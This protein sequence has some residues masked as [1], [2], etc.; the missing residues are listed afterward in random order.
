MYRLKL[1]LL[2]C[3]IVLLSLLSGCAQ[4]TKIAML[5]PAEIDIKAKNIAVL[6]FKGD[7][8]TG[9]AGKL[10]AALTRVRFNGKP[11]FN[12][13][14]RQGIKSIIK[15]QKRQHNGL[16]RENVEVEV[17]SLVGA[18]ALISGRILALT[19]IDQN[20]SEKHR[21]RKCNKSS[22]DYID[23]TVR[24]KKRKISLSANIRITNITLGTVPY[25][26]SLSRSLTTTHC[27]DDEV[28]LP[29]KNQAA[30]FLAKEIAQNFIFKLKPNYEYIQVTLL[31]SED[32]DYTDHEESLLEDGLAYFKQKRLNKAEQLLSELLKSTQFKSYVAAYNLGVIKETKG[33]LKEAEKY[34]NLADSLQIEPVEEINQ[35]VNRIRSSL[36]RSKQ[37][38]IQVDRNLSK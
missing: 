2:I 20:H 26:D 15:E 8:K 10:E 32:I 33:E 4:R 21:R 9:L 38:K 34:Y 28:M 16:Y 31:E 13:V 36:I 37:A 23:Y 14:D 22:C 17:G 27:S 30:Q 18:S 3:S 19:K 12:V 25:S 24:C 11:Y 5:Q 6:P 7:I 1:G 29:S 35:A